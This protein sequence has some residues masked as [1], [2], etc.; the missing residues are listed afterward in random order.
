MTAV[1]YSKKDML[2]STF[3]CQKQHQ[4]QHTTVAVQQTSVLIKPWL[5][6]HVFSRVQPPLINIL[7]RTT[8]NTK[9]AKVQPQCLEQEEQQ[10]SKLRFKD[11]ES[12]AQN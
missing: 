3:A 4:P 12:D 5:T 11:G 6:K 1:P 8:T 10:D 2:L 7:V 9:L